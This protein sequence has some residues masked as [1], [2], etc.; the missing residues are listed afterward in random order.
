MLNVQ[1]NQDKSCDPDGQAEYVDKRC[2]LVSPEDA[3]SDD[4]EAV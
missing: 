3:K 4:K 1:H 2:D